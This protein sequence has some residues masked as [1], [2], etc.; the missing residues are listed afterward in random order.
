MPRAFHHDYRAKSIYRITMAKATGIP[1]FGELAGVLPDVYIQKS[2]MGAIIEQ[3]LRLFGSL[4]ENLR[5]L[6]YVIMPDHIHFLIHVTEQLDK[7]LGLYIG[8]FKVKTG[9]DYGKLAGVK[10]TIFER[11]FYDCIVYPSRSLDAVYDYIRLNP[12]RLAVRRAYPEYFSRVNSLVVGGR[13]LQAYGNMLLLDNPFKEQDVVHRADSPEVRESNRRRWLY[14]AA[15]GGVLVSP[16]ISPDERGIRE[17][18][19]ELGGKCIVLTSEAFGE[20]YKPHGHDFELCETGRLLILSA[21]AGEKTLSRA[22]CLALN[23]LAEA[24]CRQ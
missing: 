20:R 23:A 8:M 12:Y 10:T 21:P 7:P 1:R 22:T 13:E 2:P 5:L 15:N 11:D 3:N 18:A 17:E 14:T 19:E 6:Q 9:H 24:M 16:F 4:S